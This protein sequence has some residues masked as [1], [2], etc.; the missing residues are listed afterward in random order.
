MSN[1]ES[2]VQPGSV[3]DSKEKWVSHDAQQI[4]EEPMRNPIHVIAHVKL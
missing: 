2:G 1:V 4:G 3:S